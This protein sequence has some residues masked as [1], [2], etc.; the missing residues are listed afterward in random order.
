ML[1]LTVVVVIGGHDC[2]KIGEFWST[3]LTFKYKTVLSDVF[4]WPVL[5][6]ES[7]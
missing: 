7:Q 1:G 4:H 2:K 3:L 6:S 5:N